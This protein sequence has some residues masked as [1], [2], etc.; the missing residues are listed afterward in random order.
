MFLEKDSATPDPQN[1]MSPT[2]H[3][4][5]IIDPSTPPPI[6]IDPSILDILETAAQLALYK[7][8]ANLSL[9]IIIMVVNF[10][11]A[12]FYVVVNLK[13]KKIVNYILLNQVRIQ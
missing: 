7:K 5:I 3:P 10:F 11:A 1:T 4:P 13:K 12:T 2:T 9:G 8:Y 6:I